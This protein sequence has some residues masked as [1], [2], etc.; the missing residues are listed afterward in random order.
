M[1]N[2]MLDELPNAWNGYPID[3]SFRTGI[4]IMQCLQDEEFDKNERITH[5]LCMLF[6]HENRRPDIKEAKEALQWFMTGFNHDRNKKKSDTKKAFDFDIDQ[7]RIYSAFLNQYGI[8]LNTA[9]MHW[10]V[11]MGLLSNLDECAFTRVIDVRTKKINA[12]DSREVKKALSEAKEV[13]RLDAEKEKGL[14]EEEKARDEEALKL[15]N[16]LRN[17]NK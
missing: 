17:K 5:A 10:F 15:F 14:T 1:F 7:W 12:K 13:Y 2:V 3:S 6:P 4:Q 9:N 11:F 16:R 8:D